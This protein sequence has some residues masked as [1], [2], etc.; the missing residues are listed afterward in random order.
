[1]DQIWQE[2]V[3]PGLYTVGMDPLEDSRGAFH[4]IL[5]QA[6]AGCDPLLFDEIYWS[7]SQVGVARGM[8]FQVPPHHGR[9][10]VFA[11]SGEV[12]DLVIDLRVGSPTF[13]HLWEK[14]LSPRSQGVLLPTGC[15]H[16]F[17]VT[18]SPATLVYAQEGAYDKACDTGVSLKSLKISQSVDALELSERDEALLQLADFASPFVFDPSKYVGWNE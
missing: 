3:I 2:Q 16:G 15:A 11:T 1:M 7:N 18:K 10:L 14:Q 6:P 12:L 9:K 4:K 17:L 5:A 13:H 8:H